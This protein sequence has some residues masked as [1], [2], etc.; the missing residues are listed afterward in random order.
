MVQDEYPFDICDLHLQLALSW[1]RV[2]DLI[3]GFLKISPND[4][5]GWEDGNRVLLHF[6][7]CA[8]LACEQMPNRLDIDAAIPL[9]ELLV[10]AD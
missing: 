3:K 9:V 8:A 5:D 2:Q 6:L 10:E 1:K 4:S 7:T